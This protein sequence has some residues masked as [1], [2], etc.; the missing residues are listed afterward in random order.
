MNGRNK[1]IVHIIIIVLIA[2]YRYRKIL[3][4]SPERFFSP[5]AYRFPKLGPKEEL[6]AVNIKYRAENTNIYTLYTLA[7]FNPYMNDIMI[8]VDVL[9]RL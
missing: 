6:K 3:N 7:S 9:I 2:R 8:A 5:D 4:I 1:N